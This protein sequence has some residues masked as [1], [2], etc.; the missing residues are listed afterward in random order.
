MDIKKLRGFRAVVTCGSLVEA[1]KTMHLSQ[2]AMSRLISTLEGEL[3]LTLFKRERRRLILTREGGAFFREAERI[4]ANLDELPQ[5]V[6]D[7][8]SST[9]RRL[10]VV[11]LPRFADSLVSPALV[12]FLGQHPDQR[13]SVDVR[14]RKDMEN[15]IAGRQYDIG[16]AVSL[17]CV[18]PEI[19]CQPLFEAHAMAMIPRRHPLARNRTVTAEQLASYPLI[20]LAPG[21]RARQQIDAIFQTA[22]VEKSYQ[23]E[24]TSTTLACRL[25]AD[26]WG[27]TIVD[28]LSAGVTRDGSFVLRPIHPVYRIRFGLIFPRHHEPPQTLPAFVNCVREHVAE[29]LGATVLAD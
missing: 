17:P 28:P 11:A 1:A 8:K 3:R 26:G 15:W 5:I 25:V 22:G 20:A 6:D 2:P 13:C 16:V 4:L 7:I 27:I 10:R 18:H 9:A 29:M 21:L 19:V 23:I 14:T 24:T 12:K